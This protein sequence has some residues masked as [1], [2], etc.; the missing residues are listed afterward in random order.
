MGTLGKNGPLMFGLFK[1]KDPADPV[2][3]GRLKLWVASATGLSDGDT[4]MPA[5]L[6]C[7]DPGCPDLETVV[8]VIRAGRRQFVLRFPGPMARVT[9]ADVQSLFAQGPVGHGE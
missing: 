2:V 1:R 9:E 7:H 4:I 3:T 6:D 5:E 8:T